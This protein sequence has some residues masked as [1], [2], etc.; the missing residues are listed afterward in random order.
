V[1]W[2]AIHGDQIDFFLIEEYGLRA[3]RAR[4][5]HV[6]IGQDQAAFR[7]DDETRGLARLIALGIEGARAVDLNRYH[8]R[9]DTLERAIPALL[10]RGQ[11]P[12]GERRG[13]Q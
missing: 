10:L 2:I 5:D 12:T 7:V 6:P 1:H 9:S 8:T 11:R 4:R 3:H 13:N